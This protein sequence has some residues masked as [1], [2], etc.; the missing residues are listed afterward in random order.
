[1]KT[2]PNVIA[3]WVPDGI[4]PLGTDGFGRSDSR[5]ALR[6]FFGV[7]AEG[8][9]VAALWELARREEIEMAR[10]HEAIAELGVEPEAPNPARS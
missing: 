2:L 1:V 10:V 5:E 3:P 7:D 8:V 4:Q 6:R 9:C